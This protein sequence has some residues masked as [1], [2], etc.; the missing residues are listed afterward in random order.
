MRPPP[1]YVKQLYG[2]HC[3]PACICAVMDKDGTRE[4]QEDINKRYCQVGPTGVD[5]MTVEGFQRYF[6]ENN[7]RYKYRSDVAVE[8]IEDLAGK[9]SIIALLRQND[10]GHAVVF[11]KL[12][13]STVY[14]MDP[15]RDNL[16]SLTLAAFDEQLEGCLLVKKTMGSGGVAG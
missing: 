13:N 4:E 15:A 8:E 11:W 14:V 9:W 2:N 5:V 12:E 7:R 6:D 3:G 1:R 10:K 16:S